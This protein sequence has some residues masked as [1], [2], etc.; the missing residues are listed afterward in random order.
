[1]DRLKGKT[2]LVTGAAQGIGAALARGL[3]VKGA[4]VVIA[5]I[6]PG[7]AVA[8]EI[9]EQGGQLPDD[10]VGAVVFLVS[11]ESNFITGQTLV[12]DGGSV[13]H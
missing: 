5:D 8:E 1:M 11:D 12:V 10:L 3:A 6:L 13:M 2:V 9:R 7:E 4:A